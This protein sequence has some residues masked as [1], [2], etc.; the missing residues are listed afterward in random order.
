MPNSNRRVAVFGTVRTLAMCAVLVAMSII[1]GKYLAIRGG[2]IL[3]FSFENLPILMAGILFGPAAGVV[4]AVAADLVGCV[5]VG[6]AINPIITLGAVLIGV[7]SGLLARL[8]TRPNHPLTAIRVFA[9]VF[10][11]HI[12]GSVLVKS[13]G[14]WIY[15]AT[16]W[17]ILLTRIPVYLV[18]AAL[19]GT[20]L[21]L[22]ARNRVFT[23]EL[24]KL[25]SR[26]S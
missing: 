14:L 5:M 25:I 21:C 7:T 11:A 8:L 15:S 19:E 13:L 17:P 16:P 23:G 24:R 12:L 4:T 2:E 10:P 3:R 20:V 26:K 6:Y 1:L 18:T 9:A 22:L